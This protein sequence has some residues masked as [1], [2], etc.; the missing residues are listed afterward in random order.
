MLTDALRAIINNL[1]KKKNYGKRKK[2]KIN[3]LTIF[4]ISYKSGVKIFLNGLLTI[5]LRALVS[6]AHRVMLRLQNISQRFYKLL[7]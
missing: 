2:K 3:V 6:I 1:F 7:T 5:V 4:F